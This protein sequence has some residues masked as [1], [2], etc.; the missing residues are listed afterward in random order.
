M[1]KPYVAV[2]IK[3]NRFYEKKEAEYFSK[4]EHGVC[5]VCKIVMVCV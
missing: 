3:I 4:T 5:T 1:E 2:L